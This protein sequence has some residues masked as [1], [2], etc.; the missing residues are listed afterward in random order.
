[1]VDYMKH[2]TR[3]R[4][5]SLHTKGASLSISVNNHFT[6][7]EARYC[8]DNKRAIVEEMRLVGVDHINVLHITSWDEDHC[9]PNEL[10]DILLNLKP[11]RI[12]Y[13]GYNPHT[14]C[15]KMSRAI[16]LAYN[17]GDKI[18]ITP[19]VVNACPKEPLKGRDIFYNPIEINTD[20]QFANDNSVVKL[21]R[22]GSYQILS[23]GDCESEDISA[24][25]RSDAILQNEVDVLIMA[26]HG[27][28]HTVNTPEF[29]NSVEP[30]F[31]IC[32][33]DREN[34]HDHPDQTVRN[35]FNDRKIPY[36]TTKD[37]DILVRTVDTHTF[38]VLRKR[39]SDGLWEYA[40]LQ[41]FR[42]KQYYPNDIY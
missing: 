38:D 17:G 27:S 15:G 19:A 10:K 32:P 42:S 1:M 37:G 24:R 33:V 16:I 30:T 8:D 22:V 12:E 3:L 25:L 5:Y 40:Y 14:D 4:A 28:D 2:L 29:L 7:I 34:V 20:P 41:P 9:K 36:L 31:A 11:E 23:L 35:W 21:Y 39:N 18:H 6:L 26:H 13:P